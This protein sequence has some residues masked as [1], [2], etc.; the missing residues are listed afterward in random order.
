MSVKK[1]M[2]NETEWRIIPGFDGMYEINYFGDVRSWRNKRHGRAKQPRLLSAYTVKNCGRKTFVK[3]ILP[4]GKQK[5]FAVV[6]L[7]A[8]V[9]LGGTPKGMVRVH[10]DGARSNNCANNIQF[11]PRAQASSIFTH[12]HRRPVAKVDKNGEAIAF[13]PSIK[14]AAEAN[15]IS[16]KAIRNRCN[17]LT[18]D[19]Y[20]IDGYTYRY[21]DI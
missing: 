14:A 20:S 3:L 1:Q 19:P 12:D 21:D 18:R 15:Y 2:D 7:M 10:K 17:G 11:V 4:D 16:S 6:S 13:Y 8:D 5:R 9:W